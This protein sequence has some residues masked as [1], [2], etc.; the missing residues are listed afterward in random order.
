[1]WAFTA[2]W[3][4]L[5]W[6]SS[7]TDRGEKAILIYNWN[8]PL[9]SVHEVRN[10]PWRLFKW[11]GHH[12]AS[13]N[14][15]AFTGWLLI[16]SAHN[17]HCRNICLTRKPSAPSWRKISFSFLLQTS[18]VSPAAVLP[19][20]N[21]WIQAHPKRRDHDPNS[22][23]S[24]LP[25]QEHSQFLLACSTGELPVPPARMCPLGLCTCALGFPRDW[26]GEKWV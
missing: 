3:Q 7:S 15:L 8:L 11:I 2:A 25:R 20:N 9:V 4:L 13:L 22:I 17:S 19:W 5:L 26:D 14:L 1:M 6:N 24:G 12:F 23:P 21:R 18:P 16:L 10:L